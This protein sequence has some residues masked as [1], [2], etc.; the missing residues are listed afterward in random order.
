[1][2]VVLLALVLAIVSATLWLPSATERNCTHPKE[3]FSVLTSLLSHP[4]KP[5]A[6][7]CERSGSA[8]Q[9]LWIYSEIQA[10][11]WD[12]F[13]QAVKK[14]SDHQ[15]EEVSAEHPDVIS[16]HFKARMSSFRTQDTSRLMGRFAVDPS[17]TLLTI[18]TRESQ[19]DCFFSP[20]N[21]NLVIY[22]LSKN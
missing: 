11:Q 4:R 10:S 13:L 3:R 22:L 7:I 19:C 15:I 20:A 8:E 16:S 21:R 18:S 14:Q 9:S 6:Q 1:M 12:G 17:S 2:L 5:D